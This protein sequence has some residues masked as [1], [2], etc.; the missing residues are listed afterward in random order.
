MIGGTAVKRLMATGCVNENAFISLTTLT[1]TAPVLAAK[2][3]E[4]PLTPRGYEVIS[5]GIWDRL[6]DARAGHGVRTV[7]AIITVIATLAGG[8]LAVIRL[9]EF[10]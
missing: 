8:I 2:K 10:L 1:D 7:V 9:L 3:G 4:Y 6:R 5:R